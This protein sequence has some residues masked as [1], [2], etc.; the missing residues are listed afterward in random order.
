M[1][2][3]VM[4]VGQ[5][6]Y[7][8]WAQLVQK[9]LEGGYRLWLNADKTVTMK[10][11]FKRDRWGHG[12]RGEV[13]PPSCPAFI[14]ASPSHCTALSNALYW[15]ASPSHC[16]ALHCTAL[17]VQSTAMHCTMYNVHTEL[18]STPSVH[19]QLNMNAL[20]CLYLCQLNPWHCTQSVVHANCNVNAFQFAL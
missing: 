18:Y 17:S 13:R 3:R 8:Y 1:N 6:K 14:S 2:V 9:D 16:T 7:L 4:N 5:S 10:I 12:S 11:M 19:L 20:D 15:T